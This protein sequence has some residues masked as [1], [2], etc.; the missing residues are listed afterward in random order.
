M[1]AFDTK[2]A[3]RRSHRTSE[4]PLE[5]SD[6]HESLKIFGFWVFLATDIIV[7]SCLFASYAVYQSSTAGGPTPLQL[8]AYRPFVI[9]T[10]LLL[11]SSFTCGL[12]TNEMRRKNVKGLIAWLLLTMLLG[13]VF[14]SMEAHE[15]ATYLAMGD[16]WHRSS[17]LSAFFTLVGT[18]GAHV[19][20]GVVWVL[21]IVIQLWQRG[22][23]KITA[24]KVFV[25]ALYWHFLDIIWVFIF[26]AVYLSG[27]VM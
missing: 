7:F 15:F 25:F 10:F 14:V 16:N 18:H 3:I 4:V 19:S 2:Q 6:E 11:T 20:L 21:T 24:R 23:T 26:T 8:F 12:A 9:E 1:M 27:K 17:F 22:I 13:I 5:F